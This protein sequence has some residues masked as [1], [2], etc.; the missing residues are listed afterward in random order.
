M[1]LEKDNDASQPDNHLAEAPQPG[2]EALD[3]PPA[4]VPTQHS[5][6]LALALLMISPVRDDHVN[7]YL[8]QL[9][10]K[11]VNALRSCPYMTIGLR[12]GG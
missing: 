11:W 3:F 4:L 10:V 8:L 12:T 7:A 6:I 1:R 9:G 2:E 5:T